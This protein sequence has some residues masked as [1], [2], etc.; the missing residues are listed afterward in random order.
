[1][2]RELQH[3][4]SGKAHSGRSQRHGDVFDP[5]TGAVQATVPFASADEVREAIAAAEAAFPAWRAVNPQ[6]RARVLFKFKDLVE[7]ES[8]ALARLLSSEHGKILADAK[9]DI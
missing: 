3:F 7:K 8:D 6:R 2:A 5:S 9:G 1:M 4:I